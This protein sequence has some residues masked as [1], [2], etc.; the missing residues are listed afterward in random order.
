MSFRKGALI[1]SALA[2]GAM[3]WA[4]ST[5]QDGEGLKG[6]IAA[7]SKLL[8]AVTGSETAAAVTPQSEWIARCPGAAQAAT[9]GNFDSSTIPAA[10][11]TDLRTAPESALI[12]KR[13]DLLVNMDYSYGIAVADFDCDSRWDIS[14]FDSWGGRRARVMGALGF[15]SYRGGPPT[16]ITWLERWPELNRP[17]NSAY[18]FERHIAVDINGDK[19][20]DIVGVANSHGAVIAYINPGTDAIIGSWQRRYL[21]TATPAPI[22]LAAND[23]DGDGLTDL[24]V[25][26]RVQPSTDPDPAIRGMVWLKNPGTEDTG[27]WASN[28]IGP[29][30][31]LVDPRN[32]QV[33]DFDKDGRSDVYVADAATGVASTFL[34]TAPGQWTRHDQNVSAWHGHFGTMIDEDGDGVPEIIQPA[35]LSIMLMKFDPATKTWNRR[36]IASFTN[37]EQLILTGDIAT[38]DMD[39]DGASDIVFSILSLSSDINAPR[40]GGIYMMRKANDWKIETVAHTDHSVVE[41]KLVDMSGDGVTDIV[42]NAEYPAQAVTIYR[43]ALTA[44]AN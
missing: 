20:L 15:L 11:D 42:A 26:M 34:Q 31:D 5:V 32:L 17:L 16:M 30:D 43:R 24:V 33:A 25:T 28:A 9:A 3:A 19:L 37:E 22:S 23:V 1:A 29:S 18:L 10:V 13:R 21:N 7:P 27:E 39:G 2:M 40:R 38:A 14:M 36:F 6:L 41:I 8:S 44:P 35:Y 4:A 12:F